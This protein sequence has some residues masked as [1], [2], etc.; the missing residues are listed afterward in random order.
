MAIDTL[1][2]DRR[3]TDTKGRGRCAHGPVGRRGRIA[4]GTMA[5][6]RVSRADRRGGSAA[7]AR[8]MAGSTAVLGSGASAAK[9]PDRDDHAHHRH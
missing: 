4:S 7:G 9:H 6:E 1:L 8:R 3:G 5:D 2:A